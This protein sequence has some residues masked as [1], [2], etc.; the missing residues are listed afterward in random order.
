M[1]SILIRFTNSKYAD[2]YLAGRLSLSPLSDFWN[3]KRE[4]INQADVDAGRVTVADYE[5]A[6]RFLEMRQD[7]MQEGVF[8]QIPCNKLP[9]SIWDVLQDHIL[10]DA[11]FRI[12][13]YGYCKL[14]CFYRVD[15][16][17]YWDYALIDEDNLVEIANKKG[18]CVTVDEVRRSSDFAKQLIK[19]VLPVN[20]L[21]SPHQCHIVQL[22]NKNMD[23]YGDMVVLI[24]DEEEF[25][26][27]VIE[28]VKKQGGDC[29]IGDVRY[30]LLKDRAFKRPV[31]ERPHVTVISDGVN[32]DINDGLFHIS[33]L[34]NEESKNIHYGCLDKYDY[35]KQQKEWRICW[36]PMEYNRDRKT[37]EVGNL[38]DIIELIPT[39]DIRE[40]LINL[41]PG[42]VPG[43]V[44]TERRCVSGTLA[45][46]QF[47]QKVESIDGLCRVIMELG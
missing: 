11:R 3:F 15:Y 16:E 18:K 17:D 13:A 25:T 29:V 35:F 37:L 36:L 42:Y 40:R 45:Y 8:A 34:I 19:E 46:H 12:E 38:E 31:G 1:K 6:K 9:K 43:F 44:K 32:G 23:D 26:H 10:H 47:M 14:L 27:R 39:T 20:H 28:A 2:D 24:K 41:Y 33:E 21:L 7:D 30:Q 4:R 22:P 5:R